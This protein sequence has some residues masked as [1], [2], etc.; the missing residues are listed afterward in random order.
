MV[1]DILNM[2]LIEVSG[3]LLNGACELY[4]IEGDNL[5]HLKNNTDHF[6]I[7]ENTC[8]LYRDKLIFFHFACCVVMMN[9]HKGGNYSTPYF[10]KINTD[11]MNM[12]CNEKFNMPEDFIFLIESVHVSN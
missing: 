2:I 7:D 3:E 10:T 5:K 11:L 8:P 1:D 12:Y 9:E 4:R 6:F